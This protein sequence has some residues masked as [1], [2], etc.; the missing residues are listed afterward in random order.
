MGSPRSRTGD[1]AVPCD[2]CAEQSAVLYCRADS[3]KLC[4]FCDQHVHSANLLS[5]KHVRSQICDNCGSEPVL[6]RCATD[7]LVLCHQCDWDAHGSCSVSASHDRSQI[8]GFSGCPSARELASLLGVDLEDK[9]VNPNP[10]GPLIQSWRTGGDVMNDPSLWG[11]DKSNAGVVC[12]PDLI[13]PSETV[14]KRQGGRSGG[15]RGLVMCRQLVE[16]L[17][18][19]GDGWE[20]LVGLGSG[21]DG[22]GGI[23][24]FV[25][26]SPVVA[27]QQQQQ[28]QPQQEA[29]VRALLMMDL[30][31]S[32]RIVDGD[33]LWDRNPRSQST[34][35]TVSDV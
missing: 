10:S 9:K 28:Q 2:F 12:L 17:R 4:L 25:D 29:P 18:R 35:V 32:D 27:Q 23:D 20:G 11:Y 34:Q 1:G 26:A 13:V 3:A 31:E 19:S 24:G 22:D 8:E 33:V 30:K 15:N 7:N 16:L 6:V 14:V 21:G 5:R